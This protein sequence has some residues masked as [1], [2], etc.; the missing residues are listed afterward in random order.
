[1]VI[2]SGAGELFGG[3]SYPKFMYSKKISETTKIILF[4]NYIKQIEQNEKPDLIVIGIPG[5]VFPYNNE[6]N[7]YFGIQPFMVSRAVQADGVVCCLNF[8]NYT[9]K[10][11]NDLKES[12]Q[13]FYGC[14]LLAYCINNIEYD[15]SSS[16][17][18]SGEYVSVYSNIVKDEIDS[19]NYNDVPILNIMEKNSLSK[20]GAFV[21]NYFSYENNV[22]SF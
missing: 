1:M 9:D 14:N 20:I 7:N 13:Y 11:F 3:H 22:Q 2:S 21:E 4:N 19:S 6:I 5:S 17:T 16:D 18:L 15:T 8:S 12:L 10:Y